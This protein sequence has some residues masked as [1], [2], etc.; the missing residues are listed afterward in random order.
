L[1]KNIKIMKI[2]SAAVAAG[3]LLAS[4]AG[5]VAAQPYGY[6]NGGD[7]H[8]GWGADHNNGRDWQRGGR[9]GYDD[10]RAAPAVDYRSHHLR[11]PPRGYEWRESN[12]RYVMAAI[13]TGV[14]ASVIMNGAR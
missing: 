9:V 14:I 11:H 5:V 6:A 3:V 2:L 13:A 4:T 8:R 12:G 7:Q 10:W 1:R